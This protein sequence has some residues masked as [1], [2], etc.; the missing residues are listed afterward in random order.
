MPLR[1]VLT[2]FF[3]IDLV[4]LLMSGVKTE[5]RFQAVFLGTP[6]LPHLMSTEISR[7]HFEPQHE[8]MYLLTSAQSD[9]CLRCPHE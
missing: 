2:L 6:S 4:G 1:W 8:K 5:E 9:Q 7:S 3:Y